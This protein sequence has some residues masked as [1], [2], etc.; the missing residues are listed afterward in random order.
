MLPRPTPPGPDARARPAPPP[1]R[2]RLTS[3]ARAISSGAYRVRPQS[4]AEAILTLRGGD[5][6]APRD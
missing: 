2:E 1:S 4:V 3:L 5:R 6:P